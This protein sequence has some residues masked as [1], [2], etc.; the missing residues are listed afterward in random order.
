MPYSDDHHDTIC[1][2]ATSQGEAG[3]GIVR[4]SGPRARKIVGQLYRGRKKWDEIISHTA[5]LGEVVD[6]LDGTLIDEALFLPMFAPNS[7]TGEDVVEIQ[8][9]GNPFLLEKIVAALLSQGARLAMPGEFTRRAFL[10]GRMDLTQAEAV[11]EVIAAKSDTQHQWSLSQLKGR[12]SQ[13]VSAL[14]E[15]L[16]TII[17]EIEAAIDF[18][19]QELPFSSH[20]KIIKR[21]QCVTNSVRSM[22]AQY[23]TGRQMREGFAVVIVGRPNVGKSSL[24]NAFLQEDRAIVTP[25]AGTTRD[26]LQEPINLEGLS[27]KLVDTAGYRE[28]SHP[29]EQ[30]GVRRAET[31]RRNADLTLWMLDASEA[32]TPEDRALSRQLCLEKTV[33]LLN[34]VDLPVKIDEAWISKLALNHQHLRISIKSGEGL[35]HLRHELKTLLLGKPEKEQPLVALLRHKKALSAA[36]KSL[37][38]AV[39]AIKEGVSWEF[40]VV[41]LR[42]ALDAFGQI[43]GET[44]LDDILDQIFNQFCIGK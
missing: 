14:K 26:L 34:K 6:P 8:A 29:I 36:E 44:A 20:D 37:V 10:S 24:M 16:V 15:R 38:S 23:E 3:I 18:S 21:I 13:E 40:P 35:E 32:L 9:H 22:L 19:D 4:V 5:C 30:E 27:V 12:L 28:T 25:V 11:M 31:A 1:A 39:A 42:E 2:I 43:T 17:A 41:D 33:V 7:Y